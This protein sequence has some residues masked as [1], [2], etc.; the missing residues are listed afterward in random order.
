MKK[1]EKNCTKQILAYYR[2]YNNERCLVL[3]NMSDKNIT[4]ELPEGKKLL[5]LNTSDGLN[6]KSY[7]GVVLQLNN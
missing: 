4:I 7:G 5:M 3:L 1:A 2:I 6:L